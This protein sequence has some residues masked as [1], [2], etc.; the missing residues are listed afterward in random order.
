MKR[1]TLIGIILSVLCVSIIHKNY[2]NSNS[3]VVQQN[4]IIKKL[5][6]NTD[7]NIITKDGIVK[8]K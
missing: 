1:K 6:K 7:I 8:F 5:D 3:Y 2:I 4:G